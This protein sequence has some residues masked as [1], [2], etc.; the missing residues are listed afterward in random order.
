MAQAPLDATLLE[1]QLPRRV[2]CNRVLSVFDRLQLPCSERS[3][4]A[5]RGTLVHPFGKYAPI[6][7]VAVGNAPQ[8]VPPAASPVKRAAPAPRRKQLG[9]ARHKF[10]D[11]CSRRIP[12][13]AELGA[14]PA[15][16]ARRRV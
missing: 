15:K 12:G 14:P 5:A 13:P 3:E 11:L 4:F 7:V 9:S 2:L 1:I 10:P 6:A 8:A 16:R